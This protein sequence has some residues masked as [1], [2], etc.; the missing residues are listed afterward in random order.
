[1]SV[2]DLLSRGVVVYGM[3]RDI[4]GLDAGG[5]G[6]PCLLVKIRFIRR[7][8]LEG[9]ADHVVLARTGVAGLYA[10]I[11]EICTVA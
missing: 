11:D 10:V 6:N 4:N 9:D 1:M 8:T 5:I 3:A 7:C 2:Q